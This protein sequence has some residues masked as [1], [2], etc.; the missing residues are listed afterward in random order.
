MRN[1]NISSSYIRNVE[2]SEQTE[3]ANHFLAHLKGGALKK[4]QKAELR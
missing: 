2:P 4:H 1:V 3:V